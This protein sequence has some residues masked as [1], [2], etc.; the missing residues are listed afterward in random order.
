MKIDRAAFLATTGA[1]WTAC[2]PSSPPAT[3][4]AVPIAIPAKPP[5]PDPRAGVDAGAQ[6]PVAAP[7]PDAAPPPEPL[8]QGSCAA[9][10]VGTLSACDT[11]RVDPTCEGAAEYVRECKDL[12]GGR[13]EG[14]KPRIAQLVAECA[15][16]SPIKRPSCSK[17]NI[18]RCIR[19]AVDQV[20]VEAAM[21]DKCEELLSDCQR[22]K[23]KT[24]YTQEQC[25][26][27]LSSVTGQARADAIH[28]LS[29][30]N[31]GCVLDFV[32]PYYPYNK[33]WWP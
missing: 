2:A 32:L 4:E 24:K 18:G 1:I 13:Y 25:E 16:R 5:E 3:P 10:D 19:N 30:M 21:H 6:Q 9:D 11:W 33:Q 8:A 27:I 14:F 28:A 12:H 26:K 7:R 31:E 17:W 15:T 23:K 29:P 22:L 20:C